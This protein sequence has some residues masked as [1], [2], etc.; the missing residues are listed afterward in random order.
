PDATLARLPPVTRL[1]FG[2]PQMGRAVVLLEHQSRP[3]ERFARALA[4]EVTAS[5]MRISH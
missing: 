4:A 2:Q 1:P 5:S 3:A